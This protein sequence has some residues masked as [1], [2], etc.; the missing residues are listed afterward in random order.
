MNK[1]LLLFAL[2]LLAP[3]GCKIKDPTPNPPKDPLSQLP[4]ETQTGQR[5]F[6]C[7]VNGQAWTPAGSPF[8]G[9]LISCSYMN[10]RLAVVVSRSGN[11]DG[12]STF[13]RISL[14]LDKVNQ[15]G[16]YVANDSI[17]R[18]A[19][20]EDFNNSCMLT[21]TTA[22]AG[23]IEL[24]KLDP[25]NRIASGRFSFTLEKPGCGKIVVTN[26]RFDSRF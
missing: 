6:G 5:S 25:V 2:V 21:T 23:T 7:L 8:G 14:V 10:A 15:S 12:I 18:V 4:P 11:F 17:N 26:G 3:G 22:Q 19:E 24:T 13:Q 16:S 1:P 20:Y 9:P